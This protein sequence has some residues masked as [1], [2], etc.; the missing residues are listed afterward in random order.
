M[1]CRCSWQVLLDSPFRSIQR[2]EERHFR[3]FRSHCSTRSNQRQQKIETARPDFPFDLIWRSERR[4]E[5]E[6]NTNLKHKNVM[7]SDSRPKHL[8]RQAFSWS[9]FPH[10]C[11]LKRT[12]QLIACGGKLSPRKISRWGNGKIISYLH[13]ENAWATFTSLCHQTCDAWCLESLNY[14]D[15]SR[16]EREK[17]SVNVQDCNMHWY[18]R[19]PSISHQ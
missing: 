15:N 7:N 10:A 12:N 1:T 14:A 6:F 13:W 2:S 3:C 9:V 4:T 11:W 17:G 16:N 5:R 18:L 8:A 19:P